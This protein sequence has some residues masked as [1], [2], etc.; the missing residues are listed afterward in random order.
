MRIWICDD[1]INTLRQIYDIIMNH[2]LDIDV[3]CFDSIDKITDGMIYPDIIVMDIVFQ[4]EDKGIKIV[5]SIQKKKPDCKVIYCSS[6]SSYAEKVF[7][8]DPIYF[9]LKPI[10]SQKII[11]AVDKALNMIEEEKAEQ[12]VLKINHNLEPIYINDIYYV[13]S[14]RRKLHIYGNFGKKTI[15]QKLDEFEKK[16]NNFIRCHK[17]YLV[18]V[19]YIATFSKE[20]VELKSGTTIPVSYKRYKIAKKQLLYILDYNKE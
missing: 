9:L 4:N 7:E 12:I 15:Y 8:T 18:N 1:D 20:R 13:E 3:F 5:K 14:D 2:Y 17:S 19:K 10:H 11:T 16:V 6:Y